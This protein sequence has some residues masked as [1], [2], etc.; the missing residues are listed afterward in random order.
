MHHCILN[1]FVSFGLPKPMSK[2][3][4]FVRVW[5]YYKY[6]HTNADLNSWEAFHILKNANYLVNDPSSTPYFSQVW[7]SLIFS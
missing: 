6:V 5:A 1:D 7:K 4:H 3:V 2:S